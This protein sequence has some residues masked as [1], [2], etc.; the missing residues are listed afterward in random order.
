[1]FFNNSQVADMGAFDYVRYTAKCPQCGNPVSS[2]QTKNSHCIMETVEPWQVDN[3]YG[4]CRCGA[5][6]T[7]TVDSEIEVKKCEVT[8]SCDQIVK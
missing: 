2:W 3:F 6:L 7:A 8:I 5:W 4:S 1:M